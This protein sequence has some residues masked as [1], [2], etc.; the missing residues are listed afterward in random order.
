[1]SARTSLFSHDKP[2][3]WLIGSASSEPDNDTYEY[4][5][6]EVPE[7][8]RR[9]DIVLTWDEQPADTLTRSVLN[10]LDL[11]AD[12]DADCGG[13]ACGEHASRS[14]V[15]NVEWLSIGDPEPGVYRINVV[16][17]GGLRRVEHGRGGLDNSARR[18]RSG[19]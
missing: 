8:A 4:I 19:A 7:G 3:G 5:D 11:W 15:D 13:E 17:R 2:G 18:R 1:M 16:A 14:E 10:N 12:K 6:I 9:L